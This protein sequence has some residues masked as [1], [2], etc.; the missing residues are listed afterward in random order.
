MSDSAAPAAP[1]GLLYS[2]DD[3]WVE[4]GVSPPDAPRRVGVTDF[5]QDQL[6]DV[7]YLELPAVGDTVA[8]GQAFGVIES[9]KAVIDLIAPLSGEVRERNDAVVET[10]QT[11]NEAPYGDG[12]LIAVAPTQ[13]AP[14]LMSPATYA[15][16]RTD[17]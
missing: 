6:G 9:A 7:V 14:G 15:K 3:L 12:W 16:L 4:D 5:A 17:V 2:D 13:Q 8:A 11:V 1:E 10:P